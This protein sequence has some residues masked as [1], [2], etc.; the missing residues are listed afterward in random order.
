MKC[1][2]ALAADKKKFWTA[3]Q[4]NQSNEINLHPC[5][6][7]PCV[8]LPVLKFAVQHVKLLKR[9]NQ[10]RGTRLPTAHKTAIKGSMVS[11]S[12]QIMLKGFSINEAKKH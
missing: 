3:S 2:S 4:V 1:F 6:P 11:A 12:A 10:K 9:Q 7:F 5:Q 8:I